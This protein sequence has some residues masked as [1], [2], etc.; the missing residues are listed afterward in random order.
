MQ[1]FDLGWKEQWNYELV[2]FILL[3]L[4]GGLFGARSA[5]VGSVL[6]LLMGWLFEYI[7]WFVWGTGDM[8]MASFAIILVIAYFLLNG[9]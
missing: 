6:V 1:G 8:L 3:L 2:G 7:G 5:A 4:M 9:R